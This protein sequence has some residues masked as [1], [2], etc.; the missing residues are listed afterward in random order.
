[1]TGDPTAAGIEL[2]REIAASRDLSDFQKQPGDEFWK[3]HRE[4]GASLLG[5][6]GNSEI[7]AAT[8]T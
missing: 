1:M 3:W 4:K 6:H 8:T 5:I 7:T 2:A